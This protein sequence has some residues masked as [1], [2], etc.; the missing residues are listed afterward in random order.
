LD[1]S[2]AAGSS[3]TGIVPV[4]RDISGADSTLSSGLMAGKRGLDGNSAAWDMKSL[5][6]HIEAV[7]AKHFSDV[8]NH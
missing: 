6:K 2:H 8:S 5:G 3:E 7:G 4:G 1:R